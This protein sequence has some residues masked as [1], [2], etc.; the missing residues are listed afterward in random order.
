MTTMT[1]GT[2]I[3]IVDTQVWMRVEAG[4]N[5]GLVLSGSLVP[6][7][8]LRTLGYAGALPS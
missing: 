3:I 8:R 5:M 6:V 1:L 7:T 4:V 2:A